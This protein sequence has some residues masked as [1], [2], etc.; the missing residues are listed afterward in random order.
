MIW[1]SVLETFIQ[2]FEAG[3]AITALSLFIRAL[4]FNLRDRVSR[5]FAILVA[6]VMVVFSGEAI[7]GA[8][9]DQSLSEFWLRF[10]WLGILYFPPAIMNLSDALLATTGRPS[11]GRR[12]KV[13]LIS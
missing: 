13:I 8:V 12:R 9:T 7:S 6:C 2:I 5:S 10:Q 3:I 11:R 4:S 1:R